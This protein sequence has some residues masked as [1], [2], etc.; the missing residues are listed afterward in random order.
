MPGNCLA[1]RGHQ[2]ERLEPRSVA[3]KTAP[4]KCVED[5]H[6]RPRCKNGAEGSKKF[7]LNFIVS[8]NKKAVFTTGLRT[9]RSPGTIDASVVLRNKTHA[10]VIINTIS[11]NVSSAIARSVIYNHDLIVVAP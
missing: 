10:R 8:V 1:P 5:H 2:V 9:T 7:R 4:D 6:V 3:E 11:D